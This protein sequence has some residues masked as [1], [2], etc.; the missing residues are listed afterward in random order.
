VES[1]G[2]PSGAHP[3]LGVKLNFVGLL[4]VLD[5]LASGRVARANP[6]VFDAMKRNSDT[7]IFD[8]LL[9]NGW[10]S[11]GNGVPLFR[12][13][14]AVRRDLRARSRGDAMEIGRAHV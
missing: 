3:G 2:T 9:R 10:I 11:A 7:P 12:G 5:S 14:V 8:L 6:A 13:D 1:G 4:A